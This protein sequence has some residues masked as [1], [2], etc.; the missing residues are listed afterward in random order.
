VDALIEEA[1]K[2]ARAKVAGNDLDVAPDLTGVPE[3][4]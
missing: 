3:P 1:V 2:V 4:I